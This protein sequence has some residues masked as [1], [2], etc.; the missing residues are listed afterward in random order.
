MRTD[1][2]LH[3]LDDGDTR[4]EVVHDTFERD[5]AACEHRDRAR[6]LDPA[7]PCHSYERVHEG[8]D[9]EVVQFCRT[10]VLDDC[11]EVLQELCMVDLARI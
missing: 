3:D 11:I 5:K 2:V 9:I 7:L 4:K 8:S 10:I 1:M 6:K